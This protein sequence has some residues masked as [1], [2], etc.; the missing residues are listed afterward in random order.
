MAALDK[1]GEFTTTG[2]A[3]ILTSW[4]TLAIRHNYTK[5]N[6]RL[7]HFLIH[8]GRRKFLNPLY[9]ELIKTPNGKERAKTI[10]KTA[11]PNYH[12]VAT[13]TFDKLFN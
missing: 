3:E 13:N 12:F 2:N 1:F 11:R 7:E 8:T 9:N 5:A 10:Y 4:L 6:S